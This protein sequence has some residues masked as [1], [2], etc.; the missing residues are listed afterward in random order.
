MLLNNDALYTNLLDGESQGWYI[1][2]LVGD[3]DEYMTI[4][5]VQMYQKQFGYLNISHGWPCRN[6]Y[7]LQKIYPR[8]PWFGG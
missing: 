8:N 5:A 1:L 7:F 6:R 2:F 3:K 4:M